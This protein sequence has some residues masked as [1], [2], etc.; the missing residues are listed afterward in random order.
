MNRA[1]AAEAFC[2][3]ELALSS[4]CAAFER[5]CA[6]IWSESDFAV[7]PCLRI[8]G[9]SIFVSHRGRACVFARFMRGD[10]NGARRANRPL[11][12]RAKVAR[13]SFLR[14]AVGLVRAVVFAFFSLCGLR[15][16]GVSAGGRVPHR[17]CAVDARAGGGGVSGGISRAWIAIFQCVRA[18]RAAERGIFKWRVC[19][20]RA[21]AFCGRRMCALG[22]S[23]G[24]LFCRGRKNCGLCAADPRWETQGGAGGASENRPV[25]RG[26]LEN[27][28]V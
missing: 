28:E 4:G 22:K 13:K 3:S 12:S 5:G 10:C 2:A 7:R 24:G 27:A 26:S 9:F 6:G 16:F 14:P 20:A 15:D 18:S 17:G 1:C 25:C 11:F 19:E 8:F 21:K 23:G